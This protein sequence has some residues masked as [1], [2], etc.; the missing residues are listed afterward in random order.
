MNILGLSNKAHHFTYRLDDD[1]FKKYGSESIAHGDFLAEVTLDKRETF[2][3]AIFKIK[4][5]AALICDR[6]LMP[7]DEPIEIDKS[8]V[9]KYGQEE[10]E[11]SDEI[12]IIH[13]DRDVLD[14]GQYLYEYLVLAVPMKKLHPSLREDETNDDS[15]NGK[16]IYTSQDESSS[17]EVDPRWEKLK[18]LK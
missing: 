3:E 12:T 16:M 4:G 11:I 1:F 14:M 8:I 5:T 15:S 13:R 18:K 17:D 7:F 10:G 2:I 6:S 9:F